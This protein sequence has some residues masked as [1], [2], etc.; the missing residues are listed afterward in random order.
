ME[1]FLDPTSQRRMRVYADA[2]TGEWDRSYSREVGVF[3]NSVTGEVIVID[4]GF[5]AM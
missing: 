3:R 2:R 1:V 5:T 4:G